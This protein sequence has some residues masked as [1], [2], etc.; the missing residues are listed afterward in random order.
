MAKKKKENMDEALLEKKL[1]EVKGK[2]DELIK[3]DIVE[4]SLGS[5]EIEFEIG[6]E[7]YKVVKPSYKDKQETYKQRA[8]KYTELLTATDDKGNYIYKSEDD[9]KKIYKKRGIDIDEMEN[10]IKAIDNKI[11]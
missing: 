4:S 7:K 6:F 3:K 9:L 1:K 10:K 8:L 11:L 2:L 5:N